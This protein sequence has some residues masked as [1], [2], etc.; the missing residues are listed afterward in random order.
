MGSV[1]YRDGTAIVQLFFFAAYLCCALFLCTKHGW[2]R[3]GGW[4]IIVLFSTLRIIGSGFQLSTIDH[5]TRTAY[6]G[7]LI[8]ESIGIAPLV[9]INVGMLA[10]LNEYL[11]KK[12]HKIV[13]IMF[14]VASSTGIGLA[15][16]G[17]ARSANTATP[18]SGNALTQAAI[19][20]FT[21][22]YACV[23]IVASIIYA[24]RRE[25]ARL[26]LR[27]LVCTAACS[28]FIVV[29][30]V[31]GLIANF[32]HDIRFN[33]FLGDTTI[34]FTMSV[35]MEIFAVGLCCIAG[36][37]LEKMPRPNSKT[38]E[39]G[40]VELSEGILHQRASGELSGLPQEGVESHK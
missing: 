9:N 5:P 26:E 24:Q 1:T 12:L 35:L 17:G 28:P 25:I 31:Y 27:L 29:R 10:W 40:T 3:S 4:L 34:Y 2:Y 7:A 37:M 14:F 19:V 36:L 16:E 22:Q 39:P 33:I 11:R 30:L 20:I 8:T 15:S 13:F 21:V 18:F 38:S 32:S 6:A 23:G